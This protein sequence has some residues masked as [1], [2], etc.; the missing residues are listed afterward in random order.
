MSIPGT[1][2]WGEPYSHCGVAQAMSKT[3]RALTL[4]H[5]PAHFIYSNF[6]KN[7]PKGKLHEY[8]IANLYPDLKHLLSAI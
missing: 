7:N 3:L 8:W 1:L 2:V 5:P 4:S 6:R